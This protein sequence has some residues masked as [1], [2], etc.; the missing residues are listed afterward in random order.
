M[1]FY[2][3]LRSGVNAVLHREGE[4][5]CILVSEMSVDDLLALTKSKARAE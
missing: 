3:F 5:I 4:V 2:T 1:S